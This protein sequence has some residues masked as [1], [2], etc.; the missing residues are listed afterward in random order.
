MF[1]INLKE[2]ILFKSDLFRVNERG[3]RQLVFKIVKNIEYQSLKIVKTLLRRK[4]TNLPLKHGH[5][6]ELL[7]NT[8][9]FNSKCII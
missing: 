7:D 2:N 1:E 5:N 6:N 9:R 4:V 3:D 8:C